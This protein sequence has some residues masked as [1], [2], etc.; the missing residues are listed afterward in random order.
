MVHLKVLALL[1]ATATAIPHEIFEVHQVVE[2]RTNAAQFCQ[3]V[4]LVVTALKG[5]STA[6]SFCSSLLGIKTVTKTLATNTVSLTTSTLTD[7]TTITLTGGAAG[8]NTVTAPTVTLTATSTTYV[9]WLRSAKNLI[10]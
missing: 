3:A 9:M 7:Y 1:A 6:N 10:E 2:E 5:V 8:T 4:D